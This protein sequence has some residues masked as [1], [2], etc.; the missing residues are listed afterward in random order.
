MNLIAEQIETYK[1]II[2]TEG[3]TLL[4]NMGPQHPSTH[5]VLRLV[6]KLKGEEVVKIEPVIGYLHRGF[7]KLSEMRA[8]FP[9]MIQSLKE[10]VARISIITNALRTFALSD[11]GEKQWVDMN[12]IVEQAL[13]MTKNRYKY[14]ADLSIECDP[15]APKIYVNFQ[16]LVQVFVNLI[17]N[18]ADAIKEKKDAMTVGG[19]F[20]MGLLS[21]RIQGEST[22]GKISIGVT[23]NGI[24]MKADFLSNIFDPF[25]TTKH[26]DRGSG[27]GLSIV[28]GII[29]DHNGAISVESKE[30]E[31]T[32]FT[33]ILPVKENDKDADSYGRAEPNDYHDNCQRV[34]GK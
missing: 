1:S 4:V 5:G 31:G 26:P 7:E 15:Q 33:I 6:L 32:T 23:D 24:G 12:Q 21:I 30:G 22:G 14:H 25:F 18:A 16:K 17:I 29:E 19:E 2:E 8:K 28:Y 9:K 11:R 27:L 10:G 3:D 20:F 34:Y 13:V